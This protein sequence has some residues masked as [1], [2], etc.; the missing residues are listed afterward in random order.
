MKPLK[1][2]L[3]ALEGMSTHLGGGGPGM[4][5]WGEAADYLIEGRPLPREL[6]QRLLDSGVGLADLMAMGFEDESEPEPE[7]AP[8]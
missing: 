3:E 8:V 5:A 7:E 6:S 4:A 1:A 2:R